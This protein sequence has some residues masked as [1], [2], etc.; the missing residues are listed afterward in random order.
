MDDSLPLPPL[1]PWE[2]AQLE[3]VIKDSN[4]NYQLPLGGMTRYA[5]LLLAPAEGFY[6]RLDVFGPLG[7]KRANK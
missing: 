4:L 7:N 3:T 2:P 5:G 6:L 1:L